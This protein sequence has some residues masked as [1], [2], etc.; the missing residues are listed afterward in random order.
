V[1]GHL[2]VLAAIGNAYEI[3]VEK[4]GL[5]GLVWIP[6]KEGEFVDQLLTSRERQHRRVRSTFSD[7]QSDS[8]CNCRFLFAVIE[9]VG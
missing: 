7:L 4:P 1:T 3:F 2:L 8:R 9:H 6:Y 5:K